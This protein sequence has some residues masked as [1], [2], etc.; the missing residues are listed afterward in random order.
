MRLPLK[1]K[2]AFWWWKKFQ[3]K[4]PVNR[5]QKLTEK[6]DGLDSLLFVL[7]QD[8]IHLSIALHFMK[9]LIASGSFESVKRIIGFAKNK[10]ELDGDIKKKTLIIEDHDIN[11]FGLLNDEALQNLT[12]GRFAGVI[13]LDPEENPISI[14]IA[15]SY[16]S[17][18]RIGFNT[19]NIK[20]IYNISI[21]NGH[22]NN[23][24]ERGYKYIAKVLGL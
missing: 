14:Q 1:T 13:N 19:D 18:L 12:K 24:V 5:V 8:R 10:A 9:T 20:D 11:K 17:K 16:N 22:G 2:I 4:E 15:S 21:E 6:S 23:Y 3:F 7:P